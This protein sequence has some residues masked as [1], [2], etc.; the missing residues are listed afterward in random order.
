MQHNF[1]FH[2]VNSVDEAY[3]HSANSEKTS[4]GAAALP[5]CHYRQQQGKPWH[6]LCAPSVQFTLC[7]TSASQKNDL[8][9]GAFNSVA[10]R[11]FSYIQEMNDK[12][13]YASYS[14]DLR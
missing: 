9:P 12:D 5:S 3:F 14:A 11:T 6:E 8:L 7:A 2:I 4:L 13:K 10:M 1:F